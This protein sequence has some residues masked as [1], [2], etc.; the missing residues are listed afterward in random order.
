M[1]LSAVFAYANTSPELRGLLKACSQQKLNEWETGFVADLRIRRYPPT[2][3]QWATLRKI[4]AGNPNYEEIAA[5][6]LNNLG[7][8][9]F[10]WL[11]DAKR[12]GNEAQARNPKRGDRSPGSFSINL[13][14][15]KWSDFATGDKGGDAISLAAWLFDLPQ[16]EAARRVAAMVGI[17]VDGAGE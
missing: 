10:R 13:T 3:K 1:S 9:V 7:E 16:P 5:A 4:A 6:A 14:T 15:G 12:I 11:P 17:V 2:D 8:I